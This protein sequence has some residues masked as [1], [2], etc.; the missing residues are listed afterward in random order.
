MGLS[1][2]AVPGPPPQALYLAPAAFLVE[3]ALAGSRRRP[4]R[5]P[6][7]GHLEGLAKGF[8]KPFDGELAVPVLAA[9]VLRDCT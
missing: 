7:A 4:R 6:F 1:L 3:P 8:D 5:S 9:L 2:D